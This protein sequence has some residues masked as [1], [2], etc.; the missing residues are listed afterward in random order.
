MLRLLELAF[1]IDQFLVVYCNFGKVSLLAVHQSSNSAY[2]FT[3][4]A[5]IAFTG[6][7]G[8]ILEWVGACY[9]SGAS[10]PGCHELAVRVIPGHAS[11]CNIFHL[12]RRHDLVVVVIR[13]STW[14]SWQS[15]LIVQ[16][17]SANTLNIRVIGIIPRH[18]RVVRL[19]PFY[20]LS[21]LLHLWAPNHGRLFLLLALYD[22][23]S[24]FN[25]LIHHS[26]ELKK[27]VL[28]SD[29]DD[30]DV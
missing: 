10:S 8:S 2:G 26:F 22:L 18:S 21:S 28:I 25:D 3:I 14:N 12:A 16:F 20:P 5:F 7:R 9:V 29:L 27:M 19:R 11:L 17:E 30:F 13:G 1:I 6:R 23:Q 4:T 24:L 15:G